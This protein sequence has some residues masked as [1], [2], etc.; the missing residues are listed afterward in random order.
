MVTGSGSEIVRQN[1]TFLSIFTT[2]QA[3][4]SVEMAMNKICSIK[5]I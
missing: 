1:P 3:P 5:C 2:E 4:E